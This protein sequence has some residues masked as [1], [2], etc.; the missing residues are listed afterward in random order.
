MLFGPDE[1][2]RPSGHPL[3]SRVD[4]PPLAP[5]ELHDLEPGR[6]APVVDLRPRQRPGSLRS[7]DD[8]LRAG[9]SG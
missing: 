7:D 3:I 4:V 8:G 2:R 9:E 6:S 5:S 1:E